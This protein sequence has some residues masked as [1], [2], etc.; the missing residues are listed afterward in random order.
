MQLNISLVLS[1]APVVLG[2]MAVEKYNCAT[3]GLPTIIINAGQAPSSPVI[4]FFVPL[5]TNCSD[6]DNRKPAQLSPGK[7]IISYMVPP[8]LTIGRAHLRR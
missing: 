1:I 8:K 3:D 6:A 4:E 5:F 7:Y 2:Q